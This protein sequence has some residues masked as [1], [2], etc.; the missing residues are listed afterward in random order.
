M[1]AG[2]VGSDL[3]RDNQWGACHACCPPRRPG[4]LSY[5]DSETVA[6]LRSYACF[7]GTREVQRFNSSAVEGYRTP[8]RVATT[9]HRAQSCALTTSISARRGLPAVPKMAI[10][11]FRESMDNARSNRLRTNRDW[12]WNSFGELW[13]PRHPFHSSR[14]NRG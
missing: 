13:F 8:Q 11:R 10:C 2:K 3:M 6:T 12:F 1:F 9:Q 7:L 4:H 5:P 14:W